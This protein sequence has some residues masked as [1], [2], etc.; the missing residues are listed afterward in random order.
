MSVNLKRL[1]LVSQ[2]QGH[3]GKYIVFGFEYQ[4]ENGEI[5]WHTTSLTH[6]SPAHD[7][8]VS[9]GGEFH[10]VN[11][12]LSYSFTYETPIEAQEVAPYIDPDEKKAILDAIALW[13]AEE[14]AHSYSGRS[15][16]SFRP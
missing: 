1:E 13:E 4:S 6:D 14:I 7:F 11:I 15:P 12:H 2:H 16:A 3:F 8:W 9:S 10:A 5:G